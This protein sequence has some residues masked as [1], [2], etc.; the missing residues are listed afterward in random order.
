MKIALFGGSFNP[1][2]IGHISSAEAA[3][4]SLKP[5]L[6]LM[7]P[8][9]TP[10]HKELAENSP[11]ASERFRLIKLATE[12]IDKIEVSDIEISRE[13]RSYTAD[14]VRGILELYPGAELYLIL[15]SDMLLIFE[16]WYEYEWLLKVCNIVVFAR[17]N[18]DEENR[19]LALAVK[20]LG[21]KYDAIV[22]YIE[23]PII[24][25]SSTELRESLPKRGGREFI[26][27]RVYA[28]LVRFGYYGTK[29]DLDW[30]RERG[31]EMLEPRRI[32]HVT[33]CEKTA[34]KLAEHWGE[35]ADKA[36]E[37]AIL[38]DCTKKLSHEEQLK[39]CRKYGIIVDELTLNM[40]KLMHAVTGAE[41]A[42][43]EFGLPPEV[44]NAIR[45]HTT[46][47]AGMSAL[48]QILY[49]ADYIEPTRDFDG[50]ERLRELAYSSLND[51]MVLALNMSIDELKG[52][53]MS[54][55][56]DT[57]SA[58]DSLESAGE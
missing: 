58:L 25:V 24:D 47:R 16:S 44:V 9:G 40:P 17:H 1:V 51:A 45:W 6:L 30:L 55:H 33:E 12:D 20:E 11:E 54:A 21:R 38:H 34:R 42:R 15:G 56:P 57:R 35:D 52:Q 18:D 53:G 36:S 5:D 23:K 26:P 46:G 29:P 41:I 28:E 3:L 49:L 2:H 13:G 37:A 10:P 19:E 50:L 8:A 4:E 32:A 22:R 27:K 31:H 7:I 14:T 43:V 39:L 48:E